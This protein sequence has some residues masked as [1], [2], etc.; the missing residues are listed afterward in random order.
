MKRMTWWM[1]G[2]ALCLAVTLVASAEAP[3]PPPDDVLKWAKA[4]DGWQ[5]LFAPD[6]SNAM[7]RKD[8]WAWEDGALVSKGRG[9]IWTKDRYGD[10]AL[11]LEFKTQPKC[12]SGVFI[13]CDSIR[14]WLNTAIEVQVLQNNE[15]YEN[16]K[17]H[18]G[19]IFDCL[20]PASTPLKP[21]GEWN[22]YLI[23]AKGPDIWVYLNDTLV[24]HM[25]LDLWTEAGKNPDGTPNKFKYAYRDLKREG[26]IGLQFHGDPIAYRNLKIKPVK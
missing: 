11:S 23:I 13:R 5:D 12:N 10:F 1:P 21:V 16:P 20:A 25:N 15:D 3:T 26:H 7:M 6:L 24:T 18:C 19:G 2:V 9:D 8:G 4:E 14:D 17:W 22:H